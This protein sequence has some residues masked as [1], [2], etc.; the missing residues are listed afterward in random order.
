[1]DAVSGLQQ[2]AQDTIEQ[3]NEQVAG[4]SGGDPVGT[5]QDAVNNPFNVGGSSDDSGSSGGS[6]G[7]SVDVQ[8]ATDEV[9][10]L[11]RDNLHLGPLAPVGASIDALQEGPSVVSDHVDGGGVDSDSGSDGSDSDSDSSMFDVFGTVP[12]EPVNQALGGAG[13]FVKSAVGDPEEAGEGVN[14]FVSGLGGGSGPSG[15][16]AGQAESELPIVPLAIAGAV[17]LGAWLLWGR[18]DA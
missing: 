9:T 2:Q 8:S 12:T 15:A 6:S 1:M 17:G 10:G 18:E 5:L 16:S 13:Q 7:G 3:A 4:D 11:V 14:D